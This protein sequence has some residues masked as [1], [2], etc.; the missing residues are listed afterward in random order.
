VERFLTDQRATFERKLNLP[1]T[2]VVCYLIGDLGAPYGDE[3][4]LSLAIEGSDCT[5]RT[6]LAYSH[7]PPLVSRVPRV[8]ASE[9]RRGLLNLNSLLY[10]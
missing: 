1:L 3:H 7:S 6:L 2:L 10:G 8:R 9:A 5:L 4:A